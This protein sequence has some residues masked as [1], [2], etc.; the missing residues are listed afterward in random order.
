MPMDGERKREWQREY[1]RGY[2]R[3]GVVVGV[4]K[5]ELGVREDVVSERRRVYRLGQRI[6]YLSPVQVVGYV[7][8]LR[9]RGRV[10]VGVESVRD[11]YPLWTLGVLG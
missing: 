4:T 7:E 1:M 2:R 8:Y 3:R 10:L 6:G 9:V 5:R 11:G